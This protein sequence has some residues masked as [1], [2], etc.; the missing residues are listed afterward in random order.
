MIDNSDKVSKKFLEYS[1]T[2]IKNKA[3]EHLRDSYFIEGWYIRTG[4]LESSWDYEFEVFSEI[5][6][7]KLTNF[8]EYSAY[9][10]FGTGESNIGSHPDEKNVG[11]K[12]GVGS[13]IDNYGGWLFSYENEYHYT[14]GQQGYAYLYKAVYNDYILSG[15]ASI[16]FDRAFREVHRTWTR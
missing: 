13:K 5:A 7:A 3:N 4:T 2:Y 6:K 14:F 11:Y 8:A 12:K 1:L 10:E 15:T 9:V 16:M